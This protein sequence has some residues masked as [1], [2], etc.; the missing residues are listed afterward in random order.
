MIMN[1]IVRSI[2]LV[3]GVLVLTMTSCKT[4]EENYKAAYDIAVQRNQMGADRNVSG[5]IEREKRLAEYSVVEGDTVRIVTEKVSIIDNEATIVKKY[6]VVVGDFKQVFNARSYRDRINSTEN[7]SENPSYVIMNPEKKYYVIYK[8]F[9]TKEAASA[10]IKN[11]A[12]FKITPPRDP[13]IL[14]SS[15]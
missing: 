11:A 3:V 1:K 6:G 2:G 13:W 4:T 8:G 10:F 9:D 7:D 15:K 12:N 14:E 5:F